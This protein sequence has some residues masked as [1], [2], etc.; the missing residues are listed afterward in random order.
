VWQRDRG[1]CRQCGANTELQFDHIIPLAKGGSTSEANLQIL[2]GPCNRRKGA[3][4]V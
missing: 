2:C 4:I 1:Q 3:S